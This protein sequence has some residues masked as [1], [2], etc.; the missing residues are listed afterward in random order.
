MD[1]FSKEACDAAGQRDICRAVAVAVKE[2]FALLS[3]P[4]RRRRRSASVSAATPRAKSTV[5][6]RFRPV[7]LKPFYLAVQR[8]KLI[9][10]CTQSV[11][12]L[13][14]FYFQSPRIF[15]FTCVNNM[16]S[17]SSRFS[18]L[19]Y[20]FFLYSFPHSIIY[21]LPM[22]SNFFFRPVFTAECSLLQL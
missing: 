21:N 8:T 22:R 10:Q 13:H 19:Q 11:H 7:P 2:S 12:K 18:I 4:P 9:P 1:I 6:S 14:K 16:F 20:L 15:N 5:V 3:F 17:V